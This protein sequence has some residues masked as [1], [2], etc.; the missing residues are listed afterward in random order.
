MR[1][2]YIE[3]QFLDLGTNWRSA[4][5]LTPL[6]FYPW[7]RSPQYPIVRRLEDPRAGMDDTEK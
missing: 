5:S 4:V 2:G 3:P 1:S 6:L 7:E